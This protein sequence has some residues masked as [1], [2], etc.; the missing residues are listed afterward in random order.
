[1]VKYPPVLSV[2]KCQFQREKVGLLG[3][4]VINSF[5]PYCHGIRDKL[6]SIN[7][8]Q[9]SRHVYAGVLNFLIGSESICFKSMEILLT[10]AC[11]LNMCMRT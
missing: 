4:L 2:F 3:K 5:E 6:C 1:M 9:C 10:C 11:T 7:Q 8:R